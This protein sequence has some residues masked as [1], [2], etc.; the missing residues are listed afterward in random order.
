MLPRRSPETIAQFILAQLDRAGLGRDTF[1]AEALALIVRTGEGLLRRHRNRC[2][3][4]EAVRD[5]T[6]SVDFK[7]IHRVLLQPHWSKDGDHPR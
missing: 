6:R 7:Q 3:L 4:L 2:S 5:Q 1:T